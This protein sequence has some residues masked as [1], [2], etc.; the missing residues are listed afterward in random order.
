LVLAL[1][2]IG[3]G[4]AAALTLTR[5]LEGMLFGVTATDP[6]AFA[7]VLAITLVAV[8]AASLIPARRAVRVAPTVALR[9]DRR[10]ASRGFRSHSIVG[11]SSETVGWMCTA[12][13]IVVHGAFAYMTSRIE[14]TT[15]SPPGPRIAAPRISPLPASTTIFMKP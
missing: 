4:V 2:G 11:M 10:Q 14:C 7:G 8:L 13:R 12:R 6:I 3:V 1:A 9:A 5:L 15:S